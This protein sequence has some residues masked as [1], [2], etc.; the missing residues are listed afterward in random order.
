MFVGLLLAGGRG[1]EG[2]GMAENQSWRRPFWKGITA[3][4]KGLFTS[5]SRS[6]P[7]RSMRP[8]KPGVVR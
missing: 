3:V 6:T 2:S 5:R 4:M 1:G 8:L 7:N